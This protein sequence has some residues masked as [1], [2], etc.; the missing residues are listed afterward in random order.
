MHS[1]SRALL[2][3]RLY[4]TCN[5]QTI[6]INTYLLLQLRKF[7]LISAKEDLG[8]FFNELS[9]K[10]LLNASL[11]ILII[12]WLFIATKYLNLN[13]YLVFGLALIPLLS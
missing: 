12:L 11:G 13:L 2:K 1:Y 6:E 7:C 3:K 10:R 5:I 9:G 8:S 4:L